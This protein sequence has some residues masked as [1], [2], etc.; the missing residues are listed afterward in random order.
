MHTMLT[1]R[2]LESYNY[3][4]VFTVRA[5]TFFQL[6]VPRIIPQILAIEVYKVG[7]KSKL[8]YFFHIFAKY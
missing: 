6:S 7:Q 1:E 3:R 2:C 8:L 4:C 5:L